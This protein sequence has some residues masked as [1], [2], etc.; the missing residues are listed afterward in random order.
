M[1]FIRYK[2]TWRVRNARSGEDFCLERLA[3]AKSYRVAAICAALGCS[4]RTLYSVFRRDIG[5]P[6]KTWL[7]LERMVVARRKL[8]GGKTIEQ[9]SNDLGFLS[10]S[11]FRRGFVKAYQISPAQLLRTRIV[12]D[13]SR[14]LPRKNKSSGG[15]TPQRVA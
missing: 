11:S 6:P 1:K 10:V 14:P 2:Q 3:L 9:V 15:N 4:Q 12:F 7:N 5:L 8:E 13:P